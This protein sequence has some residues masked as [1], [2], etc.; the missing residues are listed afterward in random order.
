MQ[1]YQRMK[2]NI[3]HIYENGKIKI[4]KQGKNEKKNDDLV[5]YYIAQ[6]IS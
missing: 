3:F 5:R 6:G 2:M 1:N 4:L